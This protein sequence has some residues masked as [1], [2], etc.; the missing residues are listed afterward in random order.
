MYWFRPSS[1]D[2]H[3]EFELVGTLLGLAI[4]NTHVLALSFPMLTY[5]CYTLRML[6]A[7]ML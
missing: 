4:Y 5:R 6:A 1:V 7:L 3:M 2:L